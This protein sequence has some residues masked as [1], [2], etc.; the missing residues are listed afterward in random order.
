MCLGNMKGKVSVLEDLQSMRRQ[1][2]QE[3]SPTCSKVNL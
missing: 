2:S 1:Q 3:S